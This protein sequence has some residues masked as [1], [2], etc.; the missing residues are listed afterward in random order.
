MRADAFS[1][2]GCKAPMAPRPYRGVEIDQCSACRGVWFDT[3]ELA[4][5]ARKP[6]PAFLRSGPSSRACPTCAVPLVVGRLGPVEVDACPTCRGAFF[7]AGE[8]LRLMPID[9]EPVARPGR[10]AR[11]TADEVR[12]AEADR[13]RC[14]EVYSRIVTAKIATRA[15]DGVLRTIF[16]L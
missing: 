3:G 4:R 9:T 1:C 13:M 11:P 10:P 5:A 12:Q 2:P 7:D 16:G 14:R 8:A 15:A 6:L